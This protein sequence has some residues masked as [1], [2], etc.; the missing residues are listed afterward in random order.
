M[1]H[2][3]FKTIERELGHAV[4]NVANNSYSKI[5]QAEKENVSAGKRHL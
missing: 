1:T 3:T 4:K 5:R 2:V